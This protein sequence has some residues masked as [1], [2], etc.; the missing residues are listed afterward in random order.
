M[1]RNEF[2]IIF[3]LG[4]IA[5]AASSAFIHVP[6]Y[7]DA[8]YYYA[9]GMQLANGK[10]F[11]EPFLWNYLDDPAG[12]PHPSHTYWMPLTSI[13]SSAG[14]A[15][16]GKADFISARLLLILIA[17][18]VPPLT[19][20][21]SWRLSRCRLS[22]W[23]AAGLS[24]FPGFYAIYMG[25]TDTFPVYML[26]GTLFLILGSV[27][28]HNRVLKY[29]GLGLLAGL[30]HL[31]RADGILWL[32]AGFGL[33]LID[34]RP[35]LHNFKGAI[36]N[37]FNRVL[38]LSCGYILVMG[39]WYARNLLIFG[40]LF[41]PAGGRVLWLINYDQ[42]FIFPAGQLTFQSWVSAGLGSA[43][44]VRWDA[45]GAN[46]QTALAV[47]GEIFLF[48][49]IL[50]GCWRLR[51]VQ[52]VRL[53]GVM[54][55]V[56]FLVMTIVFPLAG[57]RGGFFHSGAAFQPVLW[58]I[59][60]EGFIGAIEAGVRLRKNW[61]FERASKGF[62]VLLLSLSAA[63]TLALFMQQ[64]INEAPNPSAWEKSNSEYKAVESSL[65]DLGAGQN[66]IVMVNNPPGYYVATGRPAI[67][68]PDG[69]VNS[70]LA[71]ANQFKASYLLLEQNTVAGLRDLF[72]QPRTV[73][74]LAFIRTVDHIQIFKI[75]AP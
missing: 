6:G 52:M 10:G 4:L 15:L 23:L 21:V 3:V 8:D 16:T 68:I 50:I 65:V 74:G 49:L 67:V 57:G 27:E 56:T 73:Q 32:A 54:Y 47:Q 19:A 55:G 5:L 75:G 2:V 22:A 70:L 38:P 64:V 24:I 59:A 62:G 18:L 40:A 14:M 41:S 34:S 43:L 44:S 39:L 33:I 51:T 35:F 58:T 1:K 48:P 66:Q 61:R 42:M 17:A 60:A 25:I 46:L 7:M 12:I 45:L 28:L 11:T 20:F 13:L 36:L 30:M 72:S 63:L 26:L 37:I 31:A 53:A 9:G 71:A 29:S 69:G